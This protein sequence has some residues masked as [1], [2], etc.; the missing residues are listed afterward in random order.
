M[1]LSFEHYHVKTIQ[2]VSEVSKYLKIV[3]ANL[4]IAMCA[5]HS[6]KYIFPYLI[7]TIWQKCCYAHFIDEGFYIPCLNSQAVKC[8]RRIKQ[9]LSDTGPHSYGNQY[10]VFT[11][12]WL[13]IQHTSHTV[14]HWVSL[15]LRETNKAYK[16]VRKYQV[17]VD[18]RKKK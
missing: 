5:R 18:C 15:S 9:R 17:A 1:W 10:R 4:S 16:Y 12:F 6:Y 11:I 14:S 13:K 3:M 8:Y 2:W 7:L